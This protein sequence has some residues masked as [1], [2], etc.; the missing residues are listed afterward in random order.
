MQYIR[1]TYL[2]IAATPTVVQQYWKRSL[3]DVI[4][5]SK[6]LTGASINPEEVD[7]VAKT[8]TETMPWS[9]NRTPSSAGGQLAVWDFRELDDIWM[10]FLSYLDK[11]GS[12]FVAEKFGGETL[13]WLGMIY[14]DRLKH[15]LGGGDYKSE[16]DFNDLTYSRKLAD[17]VEVGSAFFQIAANP[18]YRSQA[19]R[20]LMLGMARRFGIWVN[21]LAWVQAN[22][23]AERA[24]V[25]NRHLQP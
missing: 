20:S 12:P 14:K 24:L 1:G 25:Q 9:T 11:L 21:I 13:V 5:R 2:N 17:F 8:L 16:I 4:L 18:R 10:R 3:T 6:Q 19:G 7:Y 15:I 22:E 23:F